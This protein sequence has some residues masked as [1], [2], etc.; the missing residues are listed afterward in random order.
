MSGNTVVSLSPYAPCPSIAH[1][2]G[3]QY[4]QH[5]HVLATLGYEVT[6]VAPDTK[7]NRTAS[8]GVAGEPFKVHLYNVHPSSPLTLVD[9]KLNAVFT[10]GRSPW[11]YARGLRHDALVRKLLVYSDIVEAQWTETASLFA[12]VPM[13]RFCPRPLI[14]MVYEVI[15]QRERNKRA[16]VPIWNLPK[17]ALLLARTMQARRN[18][19]RALTRASFT[20]ALSEEDAELLQRL[21]PDAHV[22]YVD[23]LV[24][25]LRV[26]DSTPSASAAA[27]TSQAQAA[28]TQRYAETM[29]SVLTQ[30][31]KQTQG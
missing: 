23:P 31:Q 19:K 13:L 11:V 26:D 15:S 1:A 18:E 30:V 16:L 12:D 17:K 8:E 22:T 4:L 6:V 2:G 9:R 20:V 21:R 25:L 27:V 5:L 14:L 3:Q 10:V 29:S 24:D 28:K 7:E